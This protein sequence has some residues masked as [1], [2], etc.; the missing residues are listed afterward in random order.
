MPVMLE[1]NRIRPLNQTAEPFPT[2]Q[3]GELQFISVAAP[4]NPSQQKL[5][6]QIIKMYA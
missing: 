6:Q 2:L 1:F 3:V 4:D 5:F